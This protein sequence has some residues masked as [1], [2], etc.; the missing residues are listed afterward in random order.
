VF[1]CLER[2]L[3]LSSYPHKRIRAEVYMLFRLQRLMLVVLIA[4]VTIV[5]APRQSAPTAKSNLKLSTEPVKSDLK[6][7]VDLRLQSLD[8]KPISSDAL[9][10]KVMVVDFWATWCEPCIAEIPEF[11]ELQRKFAG[12]G[13]EVMGVALASGKPAEVKPFVE[14][15]KMKYSVVAG[16][17]DQTYDLN[18]VAYPTT[19]L[20]T[21]DWKVY[22]VYMGSGR[23]KARQL[24]KDIERLLATGN[25]P[26]NEGH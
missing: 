22:K 3:D 8:G 14:R 26:G 2:A 15:F 12:K 7:M 20:V 17:D 21:K 10:G 13:V 5:A 1:E 24:E 19:Y 18:I 25:R 4:S 23:V 9:K 16:D 6:P 11:N